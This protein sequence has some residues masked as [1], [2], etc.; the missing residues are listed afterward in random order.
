MAA[1]WVLRRWCSTTVAE[2]GAAPV[3]GTR[4][5]RLK[6]SKL[7]MWFSGMSRDYKEACRE[8]VVGAWERP[9]KASIYLSLLGGAGTCVYTNPDGASFETTVLDTAN[10]LG[11]LTPWIRSGTSDG[12][13]QKLAKLRNEGRLRHL[14]LGM[15]S[16][17]YF[18]DYNPDASLYE[19]QC[20]NLSVPW[21]EL[22]TRVL[23]VG[24]AGRWWILDHKM[25]DYDVNDEEFKHLPPAMA[26]T[27]PPG[28]QG[29]ENNERLHK[30]SWMPLKTEENEEKEKA[31]AAIE[32]EGGR[33]TGAT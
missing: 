24:F 3:S 1:S 17:T 12:Y 23:D 5:E 10:Q 6:N 13:V 22:H 11:L 18:A 16:L 26:T 33:T 28:V 21:R 8:I 20:S 2:A 4:W 32:E 9:I 30:E 7:G 14:S 19:A 31:S 15:V 25:K 27:V 29:V